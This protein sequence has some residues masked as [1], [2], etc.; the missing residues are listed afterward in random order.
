[1]RTSQ[2]VRQCETSRGQ[3]TDRSTSL[4]R[5]SS[6][7]QSQR[8]GESCT[9]AGSSSIS[10]ACW[11]PI[12]SAVNRRRRRKANGISLSRQGFLPFRCPLCC[13][14]VSALV[15]RWRPTA[16]VRISHQFTPSFRPARCLF[17]A[18]WQYPAVSCFLFAVRT[19]KTFIPFAGSTPEEGVLRSLIALDDKRL[20]KQRVESQSASARAV[21][22]LLHVL[23][24]LSLDFSLTGAGACVV[25]QLIR[26]GRWCAD[27]RL[28]IP[29][30]RPITSRSSPLR[31]PNIQQS[32]CGWGQQ[33]CHRTT[34]H[35]K[36]LYGSRS[37][38]RLPTLPCAALLCCSA[39]P[40]LSPYTC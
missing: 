27:C 24:S 32:T 15:N 22:R 26:Y 35:Y 7:V 29:S 1:M 23:L 19:L 33:R 37:T 8:K 11:Q 3:S 28:T 36:A 16:A 40:M 20:G 30:G 10:T 4:R 14:L 17:V 5:A 6:A 21:H 25:A 38:D 13:M 31:G 2:A 9:C 18:S 34:Q 39:T 12:S